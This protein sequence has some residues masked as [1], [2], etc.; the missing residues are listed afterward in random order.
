MNGSRWGGALVVLVVVS[1][2]ALLGFGL[3]R[4][5]DTLAS[6]LVGG[7]APD[8]E[9]PELDGDGTVSLS[10]FRGS[11]VVVNF[12]ASWCLA[13]IQEHPVL[14][15]AWRTYRDQGVKMVGVV[16]QDTRENARRYLK[17]RGGGWTQVTDPGTRVAIDF[18][19]YGVPETFFIDPQG[20]I[21]H[22]HIG[23]VTD[24][25]MRREIGALLAVAR[26]P[27]GVEPT[28]SSVGPPAGPVEAP[29]GGTS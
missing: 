21:T 9:L 2:L 25:I 17:E 1:L 19:V 13:C 6:P 24:E 26:S 23:P 28:D 11:P 27:D 18:G 20:I 3:T 4:D 12:W 8:F 22:K 5:A 16:Y 10:G 15:D 29:S 7:A 14:V